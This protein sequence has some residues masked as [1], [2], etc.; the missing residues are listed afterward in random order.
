M[1]I[2]TYKDLCIDAVD[3]DR[4]SRFWATLLG[5][6]PEQREGGLVKLVGA[7]AEDTVWVVPVP[8]PVT[9]KQR[10]H[11]DIRAASV[12]DVEALGATVVDADTF[13]WTLMKDPEGGELCVFETADKRPGL[14]EL[15]IDS[16]RDPKAIARWWAEAF[17]AELHEEEDYAYLEEVPALPFETIDF[18]PVP[19]PKSVKNR[20]HFDVWGD[21]EAL[22][23]KG[24]TVLRAPDD[25]IDWTIMADP[26]GNEFCVFAPEA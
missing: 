22:K 15:I 2:A 4:M 13:S 12:K 19:E 24:A 11:L 1:A 21:V 26:D 16:D 7:T 5:L 18:V 10:A 6:E 23:A 17:D 20:I 14:F 3:T 25:T 9:V 8:E